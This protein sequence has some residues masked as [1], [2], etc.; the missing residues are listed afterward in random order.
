MRLRVAALALAT[1]GAALALPQI[2]RP[3]QMGP[4]LYGV[5]P[6]LW[7]M[8][9]AVVPPPP[10]DHEPRRI[11]LSAPAEPVRDPV[12]QRSV[13]ALLAP[14]TKLIFEGIGLGT[15]GVPSAQSFS[16]EADPAD[17]QGDVG[18][19]HYLQIVNSSIAVFSKTGTLLLGPLPTH[20]VFAGLGGAC[21]GRSGYD[22]IVL[23]DPLADRWLISQLACSTRTR[24][25]TSTTTRSSPC[26]RTA[27][28]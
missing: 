21:G 12:V 14:P 19:N 27:I 22:G 9:P 1:S 13:P 11:P 18:P 2:T 28:T 17:P 10:E 26:G 23:Y 4:G 25:R 8:R 5:S 16:V 20:T 3:Q 7:L 6:P 24:T 15:V